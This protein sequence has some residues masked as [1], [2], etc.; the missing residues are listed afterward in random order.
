[1]QR[2]QPEFLIAVLWQ[3]HCA[4]VWTF[5]GL[6]DPLSPVVVKEADSALT[7][8]S[9]IIELLPAFVD[10]NQGQVHEEGCLSA[11]SIKSRMND[12]LAIGRKENK[13]SPFGI[14]SE[15]SCHTMPLLAP[16][17]PGRNGDTSAMTHIGSPSFLQKRST[18]YPL[19]CP[20]PSGSSNFRNNSRKA[21]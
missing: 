14:R 20:L 21:P 9:E 1:M 19:Q 3:K 17:A 5:A 6:Q 16:R 13:R 11:D 12:V 15:V 18:K 8:V 4:V 2:L 10:A 7:V